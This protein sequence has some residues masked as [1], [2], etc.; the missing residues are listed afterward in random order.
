MNHSRG[1]ERRGVIVAQGRNKCARVVE[2]AKKRSLEIL[3][4]TQSLVTRKKTRLFIGVFNLCC[5]WPSSVAS[6]NNDNKKEDYR[7][8]FNVTRHKTTYPAYRST[9][10]MLVNAYNQSYD[11]KEKSLTWWLV[12]YLDTGYSVVN[13]LNWFLPQSV[14]STI[15]PKKKIVMMIREWNDTI[16]CWNWTCRYPQCNWYS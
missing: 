12:S 9:I 5:S 14:C 15:I 8:T 11:W 16:N 4:T 7:Y 1:G 3:Y 6:S 13:Q 10:F 2:L